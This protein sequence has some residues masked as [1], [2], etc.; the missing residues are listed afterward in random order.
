MVAAAVAL[1]SATQDIVID[2]YRIECAES[3]MQGVLAAAYQYGY[4]TAMLVGTACAL[5]SPSTHHGRRVYGDGG[6][7]VD[8]Y[9]TT[10]GVRNPRERCE[11]VRKF[12]CVEKVGNGFTR[13]DR[14]IRGFPQAIW[15]LCDRPAA[16]HFPVS[17]SDYVLG[18][19]AN[20]FYLDIG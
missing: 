7:C 14:S 17:L 13:G 19:L 16:V 18:I 3:R 8:R 6:V 11:S 5:A 1:S 4:R 15:S 10:S 12:E 9:C 20:P 2:A